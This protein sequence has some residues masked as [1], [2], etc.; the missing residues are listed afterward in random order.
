MM[1]K[2]TLVSALLC[3][4][5]VTQASGIRTAY[6]NDTRM[7]P[8]NLKMGKASVLRFSEKPKKVVIGNQNYYSIE[9]IE[10]DLTIQP[11]GRVETNLFVY[12]PYHNYGF[13]LRVCSS[14]RYDDLVY[15]K[16]KSK[17]RPLPKPKKVERHIPGF[18]AIGI[19]FNVGKD[20]SATVIRTTVD[21]NRQLWLVD[22]QLKNESSVKVN[23]ATTRPTESE[24]EQRYSS[25]KPRRYC[26]RLPI[27]LRSFRKVQL[28]TQPRKMPLS[29]S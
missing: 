1:Q 20:I 2:I 6:V 14:C 18:K 26:D 3:Y 22:L 24:L 29:V 12:T 28:T 15:V 16:W 4:P 13:I 9:F 19:R 21:A 25:L 8:I 7:H 27:T 10:N 17:Y 5:L 11:L 23:I